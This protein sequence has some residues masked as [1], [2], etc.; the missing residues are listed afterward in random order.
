VLSDEQKRSMYDQFGEAGLKG[1][2][3]G[4]AGAYGAVCGGIHPYYFLIWFLL[5]ILK[6]KAGMSFVVGA[7]FAFRYPSHQ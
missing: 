2:A 7:P 4:G 6:L 1:G 3:A 5:Y